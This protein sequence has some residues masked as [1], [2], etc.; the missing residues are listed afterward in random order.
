MIQGFSKKANL[1]IGSGVL[2]Q[3]IYWSAEE[4]QFNNLPIIFLLLG[5]ILIAIGCIYY[6]KSKGYSGWSGFFIGLLGV[7]GVLLLFLSPDKTKTPKI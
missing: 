6:S 1:Y 5:I 7:I 4:L 2:F 3:L